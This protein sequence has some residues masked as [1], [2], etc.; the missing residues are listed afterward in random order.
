MQAEPTLAPARDRS[1]SRHNAAVRPQRRPTRGRRPVAGLARP[2]E[3]ESS[4]VAGALSEPQAARARADGVIAAA[5]AAG[6]PLR[7]PLGRP[8]S[9]VTL[10]EYRRGRKPDNAGK[11]YPAEP[12]EP[13]EIAALLDALP[14]GCAGVR[15]AALVVLLWRAALRI[16]EALALAPKD[17]VLSSGELRVLHGK[18]DRWRALELALALERWHLADR[19]SDP[20]VSS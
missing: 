3:G 16:A 5:A 14:K 20:A 4:G 19:Y 12:L 2:G 6:A 11:R 1:A 13:D 9:P 15:D 17:L 10:P 7:D 8:M 18:G